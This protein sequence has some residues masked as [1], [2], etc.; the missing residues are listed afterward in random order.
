MFLNDYWFSFFPL[1]KHVL[2]L[3]EAD[4]E[5]VRNELLW[6]LVQHSGEDPPPP[7]LYT[8]FKISRHFEI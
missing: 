2:L 5:A 6:D 4:I 8:I 7:N 1:R 3:L